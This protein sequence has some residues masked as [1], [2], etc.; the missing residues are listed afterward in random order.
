MKMC[1]IVYIITFNVSIAILIKYA[2]TYLAVTHSLTKINIM[3][4]AAKY[5]LLAIHMLTNL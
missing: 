4:A 3:N 1:T 2:D 5:E